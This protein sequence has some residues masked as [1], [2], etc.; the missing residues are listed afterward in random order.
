V[1]RYIIRTVLGEADFGLSSAFI[2]DGENVSVKLLCYDL[3]YF[4]AMSADFT[5]PEG[6]REDADGRPIVP[7]AGLLKTTDFALS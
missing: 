7:V 4:K 6:T 2:G 1:P 3:A 5:W